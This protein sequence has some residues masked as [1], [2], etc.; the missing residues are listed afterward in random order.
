MA[1][2]KHT[3][4]RRLKLVFQFLQLSRC[5][6]KLLLEVM[7][8]AMDEG[9]HQAKTGIQWATPSPMHGSSALA[10]SSSSCSDK[11]DNSA[12]YAQ[13]NHPSSQP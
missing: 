11:T 6:L 2:V 13:S 7:Q 5:S 3:L 1:Q 12:Q 10:A 8:Q 9:Q 4:H